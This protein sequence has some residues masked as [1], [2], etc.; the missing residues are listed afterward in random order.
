MPPVHRAAGGP[1]TVA[2]LGE[3]ALVG[4][5]GVAGSRVKRCAEIERDRVTRPAASEYFASVRAAGH[6]RERGQT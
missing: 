1:Y 4:R 2:A 3:Q 5:I 6:Q